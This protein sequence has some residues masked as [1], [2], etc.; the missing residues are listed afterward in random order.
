MDVIKG[1]TGQDTM[2]AHF[3]RKDNFEFLPVCKL[4]FFG[5]HKPN[6]PN[7]GKAEKKRIRMVPCNL[8]LSKAEIDV[9]LPDRLKA[10]GPGILRLLIDNCVKWQTE[11]LKVPSCVE[12][13]TENYFYTQNQ[14]GKWLEACCIVGPNKSAPTTILWKSWQVWAKEHSVEVGTETA[15]SESLAE[16]HFRYDKHARGKDNKEY[17][18]WHGLE[19]ADETI[20]F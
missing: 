11:G 8:Q 15:F 18:G 3:M 5:N 6:L 12:E 1:I 7:V 10:E 19:I 13:Q 20:P 9:G 14:F 2:R 16:A 4:I 17:R